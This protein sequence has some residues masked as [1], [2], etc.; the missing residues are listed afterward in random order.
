MAIYPENAWKNLIARKARGT[1]QKLF[2]LTFETEL[3]QQEKLSIPDAIMRKVGPFLRNRE[4]VVTSCRD[5]VEVW[6]KKQ[7]DQSLE[8]INR[9]LAS[10]GMPHL[11]NLFI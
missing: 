6:G 4:M 9:I 8:D 1:K 3:K 5:H 2:S 7:W 10:E 11:F